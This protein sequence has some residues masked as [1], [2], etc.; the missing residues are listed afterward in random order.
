MQGFG[1]G[2]SMVK[3]F[4]DSNDID[5]HFASTPN[6]G[7]TVSLKFKKNKEDI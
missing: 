4:C 5:L 7:T 6:K 3:R 1:I 2:L